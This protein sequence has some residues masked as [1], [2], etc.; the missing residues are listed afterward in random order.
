MSK[1]AMEYPPG[2]HHPTLWVVERN[3]PVSGRIW[4]EVWGRR[5]G[6]DMTFAIGA[7]RSLRGARKH[8]RVL[9]PAYMWEEAKQ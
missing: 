1:K 3:N 4:W 6:Y 8:M 9:S 5:R 2:S 7:F